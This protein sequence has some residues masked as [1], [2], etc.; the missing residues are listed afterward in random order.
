MTTEEMEEIFPKISELGSM[1]HDDLPHPTSLESEFHCWHMKWKEQEKDH[2]FSSLPMTLSHTLPHASSMFLNIRVLLSIIC[3]LPVTSCSSE[4]SFSG[5]K[6]I[7]TPVRSTMSNERLS[8]LSLLHLHQD[9][10]INTSDIIDEFVR[11]HPRRI[12]LSNILAD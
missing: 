4:R 6:R 1:Y 2:E 7:K 11:R 5:L 12:Q 3:T 8:S 10:D 9:I